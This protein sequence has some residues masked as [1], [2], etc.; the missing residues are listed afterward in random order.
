MY[1]DPDWSTHTQSESSLGFLYKPIY[2]PNV[3][4]ILSPTAR[5]SA[6]EFITTSLEPSASQ[7]SF[8][9]FQ[10]SALEKNL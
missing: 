2:V 8:A 1:V 3:P 9:E 4:V 6:G 5:F 10:F 7:A